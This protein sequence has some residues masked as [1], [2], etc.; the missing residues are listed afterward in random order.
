MALIH[1]HFSMRAQIIASVLFVVL[2]VAVLALILGLQNRR[3]S[4]PSG[5]F[6][7]RTLSTVA[8]RDVAVTL[9]MWL[10]AQRQTL[11]PSLQQLQ[12]HDETAVRTWLKKHPQVAQLSITDDR[13][14]KK[15]WRLSKS[16]APCHPLTIADRVVCLE[17]AHL[18]NV[19]INSEQNVRLQPPP[20]RPNARI[21]AVQPLDT[22]PKHRQSSHFYDGQ[23][24]VK[25]KRPLDESELQTIQREIAA[26]P[27]KQWQT[28]YVFASQTTDEQRM[29]SYFKRWPIEY[30]EAHYMYR[31]NRKPFQPNDLLYAPYQWNLP[32]IATAAGWQLSKG[33]G[34]VTVA[35]IDTG[36]DLHHPD[37]VRH[38]QSGF[39][40]LNEQQPPQ[41]DVG[42]GTH[43]AGVIGAAVNNVE[44]VAGMSW[45]NPILPVKVLDETGT[46]NSFDVA[47][48]IIWATDRGAKVIN[49]S[50]GNY[51]AGRFLHD[52]VRY[53]FARDVV[54][55][56]ASGNEATDQPG[57]PAAYPE[58]LAVSAIDEQR[59]LAPFSNYGNYIDVVAPGVHIASTFPGQSYAALSGTSMATPHVSA[60]AALIR[61]RYPSLRNREVMDI[62]R[63][64]AV[65]LGAKGFDSRYGHGLIHVQRALLAAETRTKARPLADERPPQPIQE[66]N[67]IKIWFLKM[68]ETFKSPR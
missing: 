17:A 22:H 66:P 42:H 12:P 51:V 40:A 48:G 9:Q 30:A 41:D 29:I 43:I 32:A 46:G 53:A 49:L 20:R 67:P 23:V 65:D 64:S 44:G 62:I 14:R 35:V 19:R 4:R 45:Y 39:N 5:E 28:F 6:A 18:R 13:G 27:I 56:A 50:L 10:R 60:L 11:A 15:T 33:N 24:A 1:R 47:R 21:H 2:L 7:Q 38:L 25:F 59:K 3:D 68:L 36:V 8:A 16:D 55:I 37:L 31:T 54:L 61:S 63:R 58:V 34:S 26:I 57:Y 52:A